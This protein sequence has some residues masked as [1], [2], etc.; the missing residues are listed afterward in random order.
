MDL[1]K[2]ER[3]G[4]GKGL[5]TCPEDKDVPVLITVETHSIV[6]SG[7]VMCGTGSDML[8]KVRR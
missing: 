2:K 1:R 6:E 7:E 4:R 8:S 3:E 5:K